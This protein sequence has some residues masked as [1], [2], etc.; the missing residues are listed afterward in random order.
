[1]SVEHACAAAPEIRLAKDARRTMW[2][3]I[4]NLEVGGLFWLEAR[5][6]RKTS[7][8]DPGLYII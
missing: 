8:H 6:A 2:I 3:L 7:V 1:M 4:A 5:S